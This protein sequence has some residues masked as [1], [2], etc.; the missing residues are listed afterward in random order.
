MRGLMNW[1]A[2]R[3]LKFEPMT[4]FGA[5]GSA[6][7]WDSIAVMYNAMSD[8]ESSSTKILV[9]A[10]PITNKDSVLDIGCGPGR[11]SIAIAKRAKSVTALDA[12]SKML[13]FCKKNAKNAK[14][15]NI[16]FVKKSWLDDDILNVVGKHDVV[17]ASRSV[18]LGDLKLINAA[19][20]K[21][22]CLTCFLED[23]PSLRE[24]WLDLLEGI[25][26][27]ANQKRSKERDVRMFGYNITFNML[28]DLGANVNVRIF[29]TI[30]EKKFKS[31]DDAYEYFKFVGD[32]PKSKERIY[33]KNIDRWIEVD[34]DGVRFNRKTKS[35]AMWWKTDE[36][37]FE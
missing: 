35:Y 10:L 16:N 22:A 33:R 20:N 23:Y 19:A 1:Q 9:D 37:K 36:V 7:N 26:D 21:Y 28:Y 13:E 29:D 27:R 31:K 17:I 2:I 4:K 25:D 18:G 14:L 30:Y 5:G 12:F 8:L 24:I 32:I 3:E 6:V 34:N 11:L 15:N